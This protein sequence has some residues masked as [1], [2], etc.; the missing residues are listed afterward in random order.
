MKNLKIAFLV[1]LILVLFPTQ[2]IVSARFPVDDVTYTND[3]KSSC[4]TVQNTP[5]F[6]IVYGSVLLNG[7]SAPVGSLVKA[8]SPRNDLVGCY[9]VTSTGNYGTMYIYGEDLSVDPPIPGMRSNEEVTF[10]IEEIQATA[11]PPLSW[12]NDKDL[13]EINL[14]SAGVSASFSATPVS[15]TAPFVVQFSD[16]SSGSITSW[17]W[18]FGDGQ[19]STESNPLHTF[20]EPG[21]YTVSLTINGPSGSDTETKSNYISVYT[22][23]NASFNAD[24][25]NGISPLLV[26]F[27]NT[28]TGSFTNLVWNFGDGG[29]ST[30]ANPNHTY[31]SG[32]IYSVSLTASGQGGTDTEIKSNYI[33]IYSPVTANFSSDLTSGSAP[34]SVNFTNTS[35]GDY[36]NL[37]WDFGDGVTSTDTN[38]IHEFS[39]PGTYTVILTASGPGGVHQ[40]NSTIYVYNPVDANFSAIL[41]SGIA[42]LNVTFSNIS[43]GDFTSSLWEFGDGST[44]T[45]RNP[46]HIYS[47][48]GV[49]TVTLTV[50]GLGGTDN[51]I[52]SD[53]IIV[54][55]P[56][57]A[58]FTGSPTSGIAPFTVNFSNTSSG[59]FS[60]QSWN[61]G[62]GA[63]STLSNPT[64]E[65]TTAG[66]YSVSLTIDGPGGLDEV[67]KN[68]YITVYT[69]VTAEFTA[70]P[71][72]GLSPLQVN[73]L[74]Q[75]SGSYDSF[76][77]DFGD[78]STSDEEN[79]THTYRSGGLYTVA[80]IAS[81][82]GGTDLEV[83]TG[84]ITITQDL[85]ANFSITP[86]S[87]Y[88][89]LTVQLTN[90]ST[91][92]YTTILWDF[93][94][95]SPTTDEVNP[96]HTYT[97]VGDYTITLT[98]FNSGDQ[99]DYQ[100]VV[101]VI[102]NNIFLPM[103]VR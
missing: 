79:P 53:Y 69:A 73:F 47:E 103:L 27:T 102:P 59:D 78:G 101:N 17:F 60:S 34:L 93:G 22:Q 43:T 95:G 62:D 5:F 74:N 80:L 63:N 10:T 41:T 83:K 14:S 39:N 85:H 58:H 66:V 42:P 87:G 37:F 2:A 8:Y 86:L 15:G 65:Y 44:S 56:S 77:W 33:T 50:S 88:S 70:S 7:G 76:S 68:N 20:N 21:F 61:F 11:I 54:N 13:H 51:E 4:P 46:T 96:I 57:Q 67:T 99:D 31:M 94:D 100:M 16:T 3:I 98:I 91:G 12:A 30:S 52:R 18:N 9:A 49:Y 1:G 75:S 90:L 64:H 25:T 72:S 71:T 32:G 55:N 89:P 6:T 92:D 23:V 24:K 26:S 45:E 97:A 19:T 29:T 82:P 36:T 38:P 48:K 28:S 84:Y 40:K 35:S 81:G